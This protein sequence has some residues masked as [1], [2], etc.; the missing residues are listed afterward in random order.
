MTS[1]QITSVSNRLIAEWKNLSKSSSE[2]EK[3]AAT[4]ICSGIN[5]LK[6][7][8]L[9]QFEVEDQ[10]INSFKETENDYHLSL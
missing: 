7:A 9:E 10:I 3:L 6:M 8:L 4:L 5:E 1:S 2:D